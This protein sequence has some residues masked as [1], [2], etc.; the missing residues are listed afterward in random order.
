MIDIFGYIYLFMTPLNLVFLTFFIKKTATTGNIGK[1][2]TRILKILRSKAI[3]CGQNRQ[4]QSEG[5][6]FC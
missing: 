1:R 4:K 2:Q 5:V 3:L 6:R